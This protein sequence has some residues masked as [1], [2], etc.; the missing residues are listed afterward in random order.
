MLCFGAYANT[1][2]CPSSPATETVHCNGAKVLF[3][4]KSVPKMVQLCL[5]LSFLADFL[6][7]FVAKNC[8]FCADFFPFATIFCD[9]FRQTD[10]SI[11]TAIFPTSAVDN[12]RN[13]GTL[14]RGCLLFC[15]ANDSSKGIS[16][17]FFVDNHVKNLVIFVLVS[18]IFSK[19]IVKV[20]RKG[21]SICCL[22]G[23]SPTTA[24]FL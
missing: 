1:I 14:C 6:L 20:V 5:Q 2:C 18:Q 3:C 10:F 7:P 23:N 22:R 24:I 9:F 8:F 11:P 16:V 12:L 21:T 4:G 15:I 19:P 17:H 13:Q